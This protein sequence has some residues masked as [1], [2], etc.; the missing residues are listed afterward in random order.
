MT[1]DKIGDLTNWGRWGAEDQ[2]GTANLITPEMIR[3]AAG[4]VKKGKTYSLSVPLE[5]EGAQ[6]P[7]RQKMWRTTVFADQPTG[8]SSAG[9]ALVMHSHSGTHIDA[10]CH[11]WYEDRLYNGFDPTEHVSSY[12]ITRNSIDNLPFIVGRGVL[13]D[14]A[15]WKGVEH[16]RMGEA[17]TA[18]DLDQCAAAQGVEVRS[19]DTLL[20]RTGWLQVMA[21]D[22]ALFDSG[23]PG[24]D[25]TVLPWLK[26]RD[27]VGVGVDNYGVEVLDHMPPRDLPVHR[28]GIRDLGLYLMENLDLEELA[29]DKAYESFLVI[30]PLRL[31]GGAGSP[32]NPIAIT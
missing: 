23:E 30:A 28:I 1:D 12:G 16:L 21:A 32:I 8:R 17:V 18:D 19:G 9:D 20:V 14:I 24:I 5:T 3:A 13:L 27:V 25:E 31:T 2:L 4:L 7:P 6:W 29:A 15:G 22:R 26:A 10:L 11:I